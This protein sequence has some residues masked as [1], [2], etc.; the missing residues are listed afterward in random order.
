MSSNETSL[1]LKIRGDSSGGKRAVEETRSALVSLR[2]SSQQEF[3]RMQQVSTVALGNITSSLSNVAG[4]I[5]IVG[6]AL[7]SLTTELTSTS[8][9]A[10]TAGA[11]IGAV[12]I[13]AGAAVAGVAALTVGVFK[14]GQTLFETAQ[15]AAAFQGKFEDLSQQVG[16]SVETLSTLDSIAATTGGTIETITASLGIF[17]K[18]LEAAHDPTSK[19]AALL[20]SLGVTSLETETALRQT[21]KGLFD[22]GTGAKQTAAVLE[23]FGRGGRFVNAILKESQGDLDAAT[24][25]FQDLGIVVSGPAALAADKFNDEYEILQRQ[26]RAVSLQIVG[27]TIPTFTVLFQEISLGLTNNKDAWKS[28]SDFIQ[29]EVAAVIAGVKTLAQLIASRGTLN[30]ESLFFGN[31][32]GF[33]DQVKK[34]QLGAQ[35]EAAEDRVRQITAAILAGKPGDRPGASAASKAQSEEASRAA[36]DIALSQQALEENARASREALE[37]E[38]RLDIKSIEEWRDESIIAA[39]DH[40]KKQQAIFDSEEANARRFAKSQEDLT[41]EL[42][43]IIQKRIKA[44]NAAAEAIQRINDEAQ[45]KLDASELKINKQLLAIRD[46][47]R[48]G[49]LD[50]TKRF[51]D[52][53]LLLESVAIGQEIKLLT[54]AFDDRQVLRDLEFNQASTSTERQI[55]LTNEKLEAEQDFTNKLEQLIKRRND[56]RNKEVVD[57]TPRIAPEGIGEPGPFTGGIFDELPPE[58]EER[59]RGLQSALDDLG[60]S[61]GNLIGASDDFAVAFGDVVGGAIGD[62]AFAVGDLVTQW[63]LLGETGPNAMRKLTA[64]VLA[65]LAAQAAVKAIFQ[66]AEGFAALFFNPAEAAAHFKSAALFGAVAAAAGAAGR[67]IAG[68]V[69][70]PAPGAGGSAGQ[71]NGQL[72]PLTLNRNQ[73]QPTRIIVEVRT[74]DSVF[75]KAISAHVVKDIQEAGPIRETIAN[76]GRF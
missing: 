47:Q 68:D 60:A 16:V 34:L 36:K 38:R 33:L 10:T 6:N 4:R 44:V 69:F 59:F 56:A 64:S 72:N 20:K 3:S 9:A 32:Q 11:G 28:W 61:F 22:L 31:L 42:Q 62:L 43:E 41:L 71:G 21:L 14:L 54:R 50:A 48:Q 17:Q 58:A 23:L 27:D 26:L 7:S 65:G 74:N 19:E 46:T 53:K 76:D 35:I 29:F 40:L 49:E 45:K 5:P 57:K 66:L 52:D 75:G 73:P 2:Q 1:L 30:P 39:E 70:K 12:G 63:V 15:Q 18:N 8:S 51:V 55:E 24:K 13:A 67:A 37:R 25:K